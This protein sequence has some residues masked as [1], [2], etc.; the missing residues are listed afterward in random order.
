[1]VEIQD[2][3]LYNLS[4]IY[5]DPTGKTLIYFG[6]YNQRPGYPSTPVAVKVINCHGMLEPYVYI[7][8]CIN[9]RRIPS[10]NV[11]QIYGW[12]IKPDKV[13]IVMER[14]DKDLA[15]E[16]TE[17]RERGYEYFSQEDLL[18][19]CAQVVDIFAQMQRMQL[20]HN[21][22][23]AENIFLSKDS[24]GNI[25]YKVGDFGSASTNRGLEHSLTGTPLYLSPILK[26]E[27]QHFNS[28]QTKRDILHDPVKSD[29][30]SLG[31]TL[32]YAAKLRQ[33]DDLIDMT[34]LQA[35]LDQHVSD[36]SQIAGEKGLMYPGIAAM[37]PG[38]LQV[39]ESRRC[40]FIQLQ[41]WL[42]Q[43]YPAIAQPTAYFA[44]IKSQ[45][46][47]KPPSSS[48]IDQEHLVKLND[49]I[50]QSDWET[51]TVILE[52]FYGRKKQLLWQAVCPHITPYCNWAVC[53]ENCNQGRF[54][55]S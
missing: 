25:T 38:M 42:Q 47:A 22:I 9:Q 37:L 31:V 50:V 51:T 52:L 44:T 14:M 2:A 11:C 6:D 34:M 1:M 53:C 7:E 8:E 35:K 40:D 10:V 13:M 18:T 19:I 26:R 12:S 55:S 23:K 39:D 17:R 54:Q 5:R 30:F 29:V 49:S 20:S 4:E 24:S 15:K 46:T 33:P 36:V 27:Y 16:I 43:Y 28:S 41:Q 21:D 48:P 3:Q 32:L 45:P